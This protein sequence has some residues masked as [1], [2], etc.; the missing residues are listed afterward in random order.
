M[1]EVSD[2]VGWIYLKKNLAEEAVEIFDDLAEKRR[3][4]RSRYHLA[5]TFL[6]KGC[7]LPYNPMATGARCR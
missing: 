1:F 4:H 6:Q 3:Q 5:L 7:G 2:T